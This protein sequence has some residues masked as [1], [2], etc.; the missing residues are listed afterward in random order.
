[1]CS[2]GATGP[3]G[4]PGIARAVTAPASWM[5]YRLRRKKNKAWSR[6]V[7]GPEHPTAR[8]VC[9]PAHLLIVRST[10]FTEDRLAG[11]RARALHLVHISCAAFDH[12]GGEWFDLPE[13]LKPVVHFSFA[14]GFV[15][16]SV[17]VCL[18]GE[19]DQL[20]TV[21]LRRRFQASTITWAEPIATN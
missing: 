14:S 9:Q 13:A 17:W 11:W 10:R 15:Q 12:C 20:E 18:G 3:L 16:T 8:S 7:M 4:E 1:M 5:W 19:T 6:S 2:T 21:V